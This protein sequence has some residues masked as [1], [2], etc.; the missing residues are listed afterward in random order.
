MRL[1]GKKALVTGSTSGIGAGAARRFAEEGA[2]V[3][4]TGRSVE[5][6]QAVVDDIR[7]RGGQ[8]ELCIADLNHEAECDRLVAETISKLGGLDILVNNAA[9]VD[10]LFNGN[11]RP[12][13]EQTTAGYNA[14]VRLT[15]YALFWCT[16]A[17]VLH[18]KDN[19]GGAIVN[20]S[21][22]AGSQAAPGLHAYTAGKGAMDAV[23]RQIAS[24]TAEFGIRCNAVMIGIV[25]N[26][27]Q[28]I[29][30]LKANKAWNDAMK[31]MNF[32]G[33]MGTVEEAAN[34]ILFLAS[35]EASYITG[36][37][38]SCDG[39]QLVKTPVP[40]SIDMVPQD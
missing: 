37:K 5:R 26:G 30:H 15:Q 18:M 11:E 24:D 9:P 34:L 4:V 16:R 8:A 23:T 33:R 3:M 40:K 1:A 7:S 21:S 25:D 31:T 39:G 22:I 17:A 2:S 19:G 13:W 27:A 20:I 35:D 12:I 6:G 28:E 36:E 38:I 14:V 10:N 32:L 29:Q